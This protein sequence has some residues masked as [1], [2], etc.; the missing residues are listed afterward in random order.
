MPLPSTMTPIATNTLTAAAASVT[1]SNLPQTYTDLVL[2]INAG[3]SA[4]EDIGCRLN[5]DTG[6]NYSTTIFAG[7]GSS[8]STGRISN[9]TNIGLTSNAYLPTAVSST[10]IVHFMN[11]SNST[12][13]KTVLCRG[14]SAS[15]GTEVIVGLWRNT[16]AITTIYL[17][18]RNSGYNFLSGSSFTLYG[19]KAA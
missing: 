3:A 5:S 19:V 2:V 6:S 13:Y 16:S 10:H 8:P 1:F 17:Y 7:N 14:A 9:A 18:G 12:T 11:Y 4:L 15:S